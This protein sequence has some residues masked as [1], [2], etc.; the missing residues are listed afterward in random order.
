MIWEQHP[1]PDR[2]KED[3][4]GKFFAEAI[5][6]GG[7]MLIS[8]RETGEVIGSSRFHGYS[9]QRSE[10]EIG[11]TFLARSRWGGQFNGDLKSVMTTHAF[12]FVDSILLIINPINMRSRRAA[13]K[14]GAIADPDLCRDGRMIYRLQRAA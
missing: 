9:E 7:A 3:V 11:W 4:F 13:E 6:S 8:D 14:I 1:S 10:V 5:E 12:K 2:F